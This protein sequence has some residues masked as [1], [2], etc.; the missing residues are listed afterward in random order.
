MWNSLSSLAAKAQAVVKSVEESVDSAMGEENVAQREGSQEHTVNS[1]A[2]GG[3]ALAATPAAIAS[4]TDTEKRLKK[5]VVELQ[6]VISMRDAKIAA[7][8][9]LRQHPPTPKRSGAAAATAADGISEAGLRIEVL[10]KKAAADAERFETQREAMQKREQQLSAEVEVLQG[11]ISKM[12]SL[13]KAK[14]EQL[15]SRLLLERKQH[16]E[17]LADRA[18]QDHSSAEP[19]QQPREKEA[20]HDGAGANHNDDAEPESET[21][22]NAEAELT[23]REQALSDLQRVHREN[24]AQLQE[25]ANHVEDR[26]ADVVSREKA[27]EDSLSGAEALKASLERQSATLEA[28]REEVQRQQENV[29]ALKAS[30]D[31]KAAA[32][33]EREIDLDAREHS[34]AERRA[35]LTRCED[36][37]ASR[38][39]DVASRENAIGDAK[40]SVKKRQDSLRTQEASLSELAT[41]LRDREADVAQRED[42]VRR[43]EV[44]M[45]QHE[46]E[47]VAGSTPLAC[48]GAQHDSVNSAETDA[49]EAASPAEPAVK[50]VDTGVAAVDSPSRPSAWKQTVADLQH[51]V[52]QHES[53]ATSPR[54]VAAATADSTSPSNGEDPAPQEKHLAQLEL[55]LQATKTANEK[56]RAAVR[57]LAHKAKRLWEQDLE[58]ASIHVH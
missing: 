56:L 1:G 27:V 57:T 55:E 12:K 53:L 44:E 6:E 37:L 45:A 41:K 54:F 58:H 26:L 36:E 42:D 20:D 47:L 17:A 38:A 22:L 50:T 51:S 52:Q 14:I 49:G 4:A 3:G 7:L 40:A 33:A 46:A 21:A 9:H 11:R 2:R 30:L 18:A 31:A 32:L 48:G 29:R 5:Q 13:A 16:K 34:L 15:Q 24:V 19:E 35:E 25:Q 8:E 23:K 43:A 10:E 28:R 39:T